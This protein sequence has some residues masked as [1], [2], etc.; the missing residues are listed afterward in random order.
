MKSNV[1]SALNIAI[2]NKQRTDA[3]KNRIL[4][5]ERIFMQNDINFLAAANKIQKKSIKLE[6]SAAI[7]VHTFKFSGKKVR[8]KNE[9]GDLGCWQP[10]SFCVCA[11]AFIYSIYGIKSP[12][13]TVSFPLVRV[14]GS[15]RIVAIFACGGPSCRVSSHSGYPIKVNSNRKIFDNWIR[16]VDS[17][18]GSFG[19]RRSPRGKGR[20]NCWIG[21]ARWS[22]DWLTR[23]VYYL[24]N[25]KSEPR[26]SVSEFLENS[27]RRSRE[28][29]RGTEAEAE[30]AS[31]ELGYV[32]FAWQRYMT[33]RPPFVSTNN[34]RD[35]SVPL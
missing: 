21:S 5:K 29:R 20:I 14:W 26:W 8:S 9:R 3:N 19:L 32:P 10:R 6:K 30:A 18:V 17:V 27:T 13:A 23:C 31:R 15:L 24:P 11:L 7:Y 1:Q 4:V 34:P 16:V 25:V 22:T 35:L 2:S 12:E 28:M 33:Q